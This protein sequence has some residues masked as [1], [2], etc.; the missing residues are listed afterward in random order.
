ML[1]E[2]R[3]TE[4]SIHASTSSGMSS[5]PSVFR[6]QIQATIIDGKDIEVSFDDFPYYLSETTKAMLIAD[7]Y[8]H[9]KHREQLK[10]VSEL[11]AVNSRILLSGPAGSEIYQEM[12]VKALARYYGAK[13]LIFD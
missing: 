5:I 7:T 10:Y 13:L 6:E 4:E 12:L 1:E 2:R 9:L 11:P 3:L 8:I